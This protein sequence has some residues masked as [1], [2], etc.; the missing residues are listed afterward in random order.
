MDL[1]CHHLGDIEDHHWFRIHTKIHTAYRPFSHAHLNHEFS[2]PMHDILSLDV[3][4]VNF[5]SDLI[6]ILPNVQLLFSEAENYWWR[7]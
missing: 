4:V 7:L 2:N 6:P 3:R 1:H 5:V